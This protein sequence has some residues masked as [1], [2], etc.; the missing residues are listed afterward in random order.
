MNAG[1]AADRR[2]QKM[3]GVAERLPLTQPR[4]VQKPPATCARSYVGDPKRQTRSRTPRTAML[5][6]RHIF[7]KG[8]PSQFPMPRSGKF[9][10][11]SSSRRNSASGARHMVRYVPRKGSQNLRRAA[12][13]V[14]ES[15]MRG[16]QVRR[17]QASNQPADDG[18]FRKSRYLH[19]T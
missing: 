3:P 7:Q 15:L 10:A 2:K 8:R 1:L 6:E 11:C 18:Q 9:R 12:G 17:P 16:V 5:S 4:D 13:D 14:G 19:Q